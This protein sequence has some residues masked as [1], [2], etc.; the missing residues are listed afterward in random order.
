MGF[1][2]K[3]KERKRDLMENSCRGGNFI[4]QGNPVAI[5]YSNE[6]SRPPVTPKTSDIKIREDLSK[7][8]DSLKS[9]YQLWRIF[10]EQENMYGES[11]ERI[12]IVYTINGKNPLDLF[13][14]ETLH[15][16]CKFEVILESKDNILP[17]LVNTVVN[18]DSLF[19]GPLD[20]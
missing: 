6:P 15:K 3:E 1:K 10:A 9:N 4:N 18:H 13:D 14:D 7:K 17:K 8:V 16:L 12:Y 20:C 2:K 11:F 19:S 5:G